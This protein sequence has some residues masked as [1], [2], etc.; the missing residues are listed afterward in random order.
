MEIRN[1][2]Y[3]KIRIF[4]VLQLVLYQSFF[5]ERANQSEKEVRA[6]IDHMEWS[7]DQDE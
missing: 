7:Y 1:F 5:R 6:Q 3:L 4:W 2:S